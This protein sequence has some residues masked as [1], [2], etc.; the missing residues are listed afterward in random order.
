M[1]RLRLPFTYQLGGANRLVAL[2]DGRV[3]AAGQLRT[4]GRG[5][6]TGAVVARFGTPPESGG[7]TPGEE[8][9]LPV[10]R[11]HVSDARPRR[12]ETVTLSAAGSSDPEGRLTRFEYDLDGDGTF[13]LDGGS[14]GDR[15]TT[16]FATVGDKRPRVRVTDAAGATDVATAELEVV[17]VAPV[18]GLQLGGEGPLVR[19]REIRLNAVAE[20]PD[21]AAGASLTV[22]WDLDGDGVFE[23]PGGTADAGGT[24][25]LD[26][27]LTAAGVQSVAV[28]VL[29]ADGGSGVARLRLDVQENRPPRVRLIPSEERVRTGTD[30]MFEAVGEDP[31][32]ADGSVLVAWDPEGDGTFEPEERAF[33]PAGRAIRASA[34]G[35]R[36]VRVRIR[37]ELSTVEAQATI[38]VV[39]NL[40]P[41]RTSRSRRRRPSPGTRCSSTPRV[42]M[43]RTAP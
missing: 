42:R 38:T 2:P 13:E 27:M 39:G 18:P 36:T 43:T 4:G 33:L 25:E 40:R 29:D 32:G 22:N 11:L 37:D 5:E 16:S 24:L 15:Q 14:T 20:D 17:N 8:N 23:H 35:D 34:T 28:Q 31:D 30:V 26:R 21:A 12:G 9:G 41:R 19:G 6:T 1:R 3:A 7:G 10:A